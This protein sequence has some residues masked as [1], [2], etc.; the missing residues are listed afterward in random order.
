MYEI[1][2]EMNCNVQVV[3]IWPGDGN[4]VDAVRLHLCPSA[5]TVCKIVET[6][7]VC[8]AFVHNV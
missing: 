7:T 4:D 8:I 3:R 2:E 1:T 5:I 6:K